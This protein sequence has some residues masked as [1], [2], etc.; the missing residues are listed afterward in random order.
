MNRSTLPRPA[1][2]HAPGWSHPYLSTPWSSVFYADGGDEDEEKPDDD[3]DQEE[4][5]EKPEGKPDDDEDKDPD[6]ADDL[7]D[8][9]KRAL[10]SMKGKLK[11]EREKRRTLEQ[12]LAEKDGADES[13]K[14]RRQAES[15]ALSKAN[16]RILR[17]E[18]K[19]A[20]TGKLIN[21]K[22]AL[23]HIDLDQF[24]V[25]EDGQVDEDEVADAIE[26]LLKERP[27]LAAATA[28]RF[29]GTGDGGAARKAGRPKQLSRADLKTMTPAQIVKAK[30]DGQLDDML[31]S[32]G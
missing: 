1:R 19:A 29:Q 28:K 15:E 13:E 12:Q 6:G 27:Y 32:A 2:A 26:N 21:P 31:S 22:D 10:D 23:V 11:A 24:E 20:A 8:K 25:D 5:D 7:G 9:G 14:V 16:T 17:S 30:E 18:I 3:E 4:P